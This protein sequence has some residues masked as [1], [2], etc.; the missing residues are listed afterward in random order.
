L[1]DCHGNLSIALRV[2]LTVPVIVATAERIFSKMKLIKSFHRSNMP[3]ERLTNMAMISTESETAET[4]D[5]TELIKPFASLKARK[6]SF[7]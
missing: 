5:M 1:Q 7:S 4:L 6:K 3:H 2:L